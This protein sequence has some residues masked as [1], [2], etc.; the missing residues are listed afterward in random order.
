M[1]PAPPDKNE[2]GEAITKEKIRKCVSASRGKIG[3][4]DWR[5]E[6]F[7]RPLQRGL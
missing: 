4:E 1:K 2:K 6:T 3:A 7:G 5:S